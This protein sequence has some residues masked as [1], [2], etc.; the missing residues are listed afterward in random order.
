MW[1]LVC[2]PWEQGAN[3]HWKL[4]IIS[5]ILVSRMIKVIMTHKIRTSHDSAESSVLY[6][7]AQKHLSNITEPWVAAIKATTK[8]NRIRTDVAK[9]VVCMHFM[10]IKKPWKMLLLVHENFPHIWQ[11]TE[12][13]KSST[14]IFAWLPLTRPHVFS[15][16]LF[17]FSK[18]TLFRFYHFSGSVQQLEKAKFWSI[19]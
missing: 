6:Q 7:S 8:G 1:K 14:A 4:P 18:C 13:H 5:L 16:F 15:N 17:P 3:N 9:V 2:Y 19:C 11:H 10:L 12:H